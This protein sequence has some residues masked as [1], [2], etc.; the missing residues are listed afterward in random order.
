MCVYILCMYACIYIYIH[1]CVCYIMCMSI[2]PICIPRMI[3]AHRGQ[4]RASDLLD[5][6]LHVSVGFHAD[7]ESCT[8]VLYESNRC[9]EALGHLSVPTFTLFRVRGPLTGLELTK[10][11]VPANQ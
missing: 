6:E 4:Q 3:S 7:A 11:A 9:S 1:M 10:K 2:L 5:L 8:Q